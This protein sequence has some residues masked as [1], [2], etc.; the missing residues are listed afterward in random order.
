M[1][2]WSLVGIVARLGYETARCHEVRDCAF[3]S[4]SLDPY[5][6]R[7]VYRSPGLVYKS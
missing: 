2:E 3:A 1:R 4:A 5:E 7:I 6:A